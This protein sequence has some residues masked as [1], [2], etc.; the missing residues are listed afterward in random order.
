MLR[1]SVSYTVRFAAMLM[2]VD[3]KRQPRSAPKALPAEA[4]R[5]ST[6]ITSL[7][8]RE[9]QLPRYLNS[10]TMGKKRPPGSS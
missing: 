9:S 8:K 6:S 10:E 7:P 3:A 5:L 4:M 2:C 1:M